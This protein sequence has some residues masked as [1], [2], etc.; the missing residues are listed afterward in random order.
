LRQFVVR[1]NTIAVASDNLRAIYPPFEKLR[2]GL[3]GLVGS[4]ELDGVGHWIHHEATD[5]VNEQLLQFLQHV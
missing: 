2:T 5:Q 4:V 3:P 1:W